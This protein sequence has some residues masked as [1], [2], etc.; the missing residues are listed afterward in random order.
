MSHGDR[1][2]P[3]RPCRTKAL[4]DSGSEGAAVV[5]TPTDIVPE[6]DIPV[7][8]VIWNDE[9]LTITPT[10]LASMAVR[11]VLQTESVASEP[12]T[13]PCAVCMRVTRLVGARRRIA[14][15]F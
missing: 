6:I 14:R 7:V 12:R 9:G 1:T 8:S 13:T 10:L 3:R 4:A 15:R 11:S 2:P 5:T